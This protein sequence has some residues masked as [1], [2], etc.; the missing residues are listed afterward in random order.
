[1][2]QASLTMSCYPSSK[3]ASENVEVF[4]NAW[5]VQIND[6]SVLVKDVNDCCHGRSDRQV[7]LSLPKPGVS[8]IC[9]S[10]L[11]LVHHKS[12]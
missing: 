6:L 12:L 8:N 5:S 2:V 4:A 9:L 7:Y 10:I 3:I 11:L 1:M